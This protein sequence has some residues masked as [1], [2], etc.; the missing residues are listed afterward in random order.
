MSENF[1]VTKDMFLTAEEVRDLYYTLEKAK[2]LSVYRKLFYNHVRENYYIKMMLESG[3]RV[4]ELCPLKIKDFTGTTLIIRKGKGNKKR[5]IVLT[6]SGQKL[7]REYIRLKKK[8]LKESVDPESYLFPSSWG[9]PF[10]EAGIRKRLKYWFAKCKFNKNHSCHTCRH[11]YI[12]HALLAGID[13]VRVRVNA[14]H[15]SLNTTS[16]YA[17]AICDDLGDVEI[18]Q[19]ISFGNKG[20]RNLSEDDESVDLVKGGYG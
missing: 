3:V 17:H 11:S 12:S 14:G 13:I 7:T 9:R 8:F 15:E 1:I 16:I 19:N 6:K 10:T 18:Y 5:E 20:K 4:F 2:D